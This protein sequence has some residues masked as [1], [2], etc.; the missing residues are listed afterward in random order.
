MWQ[1]KSITLLS[2]VGKIYAGIIV[3]RVRKVTEGLIYDEEGGFR[4]ER[5]CVDH[6]LT[7]QQIGE[8]PREKKRRVY[9]GF[10]GLE[11]A[12]DRVNREALWQVL[13]MYDAGGKLLNGV[14]S[15]YVNSLAYVSVEGSE[16]ECFRID[17]GVRQVCIMSPWLFKIY[18]D[19]VMKDLKMG[20]R[21]R[22]HKF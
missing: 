2:V 18:M 11:K 14:N 15:I 22:G 5:E 3:D 4:A 20:M 19:A 8:K 12:Y 1:L 9:V 16:S 7:I 10:V 17:G 6:I 13:R 21:W